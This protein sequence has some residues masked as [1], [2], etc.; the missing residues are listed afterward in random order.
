MVF[1]KLLLAHLMPILFLKLRILSNAKKFLI[2]GSSFTYA[3]IVSLA[4][5]YLIKHFH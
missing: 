4:T 2:G 5:Q 3:I 1:L